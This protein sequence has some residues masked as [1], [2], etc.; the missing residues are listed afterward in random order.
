MERKIKL[1]WKIKYKKVDD[2][3][4]CLRQNVGCFID[5]TFVFWGNL[6]LVLETGIPSSE[7]TMKE[8]ILEEA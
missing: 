7:L 6:K 4:N 5:L 1:G 3:N 2:R 8:H